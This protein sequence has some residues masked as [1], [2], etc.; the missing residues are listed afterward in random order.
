VEVV[1]TSINTDEH[2]LLL[3]GTTVN[4]LSTQDFKDIIH[5]TIDSVIANEKYFCELDSVAGDGDFGTSLA[6]G[7]RAIESNWDSLDD[8]DIGKFLL[9]C[10]KI[11]MTNCGGASGPIWGNALR[12][13]GS[14]AK[15]TTSVNLQELA[16][17]MDAMVAGVKKVGGAELGDKTLLDALIPAAKSLEES[18][19][20][21]SEL[22][23]AIEKAVDK[24]DEGAENTKEIAAKKGRARYLGDR[25]IGNYDPGAKAISVLFNDIRDELFSGE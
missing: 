14:Y 1:T 15:G 20:D 2:D 24:A 18:A 12:K 3:G 9:S 23:E 6:S 21:G 5:V 4:K 8:G 17:L 7:F 19:E 16:E 25:S 11:L 22:K 10:S 13:A